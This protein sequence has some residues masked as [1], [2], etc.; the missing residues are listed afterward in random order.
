M[1]FLQVTLNF[2]PDIIVAPANKQ[3]TLKFKQFLFYSLD[4]AH[5]VR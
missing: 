4:L 1:H 3:S 5:R 2:L